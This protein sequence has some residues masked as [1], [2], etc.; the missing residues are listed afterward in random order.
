[1]KT[2]KSKTK[3]A[4]PRGKVLE[5]WVPPQ[6]GVPKGPQ[7]IASWDYTI[8][9]IKVTLKYVNPP[10][11]RRIL[12]HEDTK[13]PKFHRI[14]QCVMGWQNYHLHEFLIGPLSFGK[15][16]LDEHYDILS[17]SNVKLGHIAHDGE[18]TFEYRYDFGDNWEHTIVIEKKLPPEE[19]AQYPFC[20]EG[21]RACPP[22]DS[23]GIGGY[24]RLLDVLADPSHPEYESMRD[25]AGEDFN[26]E[27]FIPEIVNFKLKT[28][29]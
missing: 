17:E 15:P 21:A 9:Q 11:W 29:R 7:Y 20:V 14:L 8:C 10:I 26:P 18:V 1:L 22:E 25:W 13:L 3:K 6:E 12:V 16:F 28:L 23:G 24:R 4:A 27:R 19:G 2:P 5:F